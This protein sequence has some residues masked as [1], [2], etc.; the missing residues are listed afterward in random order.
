MPPPSGCFPP[1]LASL[2]GVLLSGCSSPATPETTTA[3][4][5]P[6]AG[7]AAAA[8]APFPF[9]GKVDSLNGIAGHTFGQPLSAFAELEA[10]PATPGQLTRVYSV[11]RGNARGWFGKHQTQVPTQ[12]YWFLDNKFYRF[13]AVGNANLLRAEAAYLLGPGLA[14]GI[15]HLY[16]EGRQARAAYTEEARGLGMEGTLDVLSKP[17]E[18]EEQAKKNAQLKAENAP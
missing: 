3:A 6:K 12:L 17:L 9:G 2:A 14:E 8:P 5:S 16:W 13:R 4:R 18:A 15:Y 7:S 10:L 1:L 11:R